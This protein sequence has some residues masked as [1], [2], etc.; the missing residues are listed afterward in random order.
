MN[1][2]P[3]QMRAVIW[4]S[5]QQLRVVTRATPVLA[6]DT[7]AIVRVDFAS[8]CGTDL[9]IYRGAVPNFES[10]TVIG[11]EFVGTVVAVGPGVRRIR[12][13]VRVHASDFVACGQCAHCQA[14]RHGQ[15]PQ[16]MLFGFSGLQPRL[17]GGMAQY[18]RVPWADITLEHLPVHADERAGLL[19]ADVLPTAVNA[20]DLIEMPG[21]RIAVLGAG[22]VGV[23]ISSLARMR[24][25]CV[26]LYEANPQRAAR[27][28]T[29]G[30]DVYGVDPDVPLSASIYRPREEYDAAID[31]VGGERGLT[32]ALA[33]VRPGGTVVGVGSQAG[34][35]AIDWGSV[36]QCGLSLHFVI[37]NPVALRGRLDEALE[38]CAPLLDLMFPD[39][40]TLR[41][42]PAY[43]NALLQRER[44][45]AVV[46][47]GADVQ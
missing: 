45:K 4:D 7:D 25:A 42:V 17:D 43:F 18:V 26:T 46:C 41:D 14:G 13:G 16:R 31:A 27:A 19:A 9:H 21:R 34:R 35:Y 24:G 8:T 37:G 36:F 38:A 5:P 28:R 6:A 23:L 10:G 39:R 44:F 11:H 12:V 22:P 15:C 40:I 1:T 29:A 20:I 47:I 30:F 3:A 2:I 32:G 33:L